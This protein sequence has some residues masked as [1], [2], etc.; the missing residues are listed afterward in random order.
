VNQLA[1]SSER[2]RGWSHSFVICHGT[3]KMTGEI[4]AIV[5]VEE[6]PCRSFRI[7][8][9]DCG[10]VTVSRRTRFVKV[11]STTKGNRR[12]NNTQVHAGL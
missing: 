10:S 3:I 6:A 2:R 12:G 4:G 8:V 7:E 1:D 9:A 5:F 11:Q